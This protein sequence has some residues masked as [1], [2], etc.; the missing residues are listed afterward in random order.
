MDKPLFFINYSRFI[1][2]QYYKCRGLLHKRFVKSIIWA[3]VIRPYFSNM[4]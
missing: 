3:Y 2:K 1:S 4:N